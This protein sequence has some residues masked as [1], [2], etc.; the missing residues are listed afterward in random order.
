MSPYPEPKHIRPPST[1]TVQP[2]SPHEDFHPESKCASMS[3]SSSPARK[4]SSQRR[5]WQDL[6][7]TPLTSSG[8]HYLQSLPLEDAVFLE[9][10]GAMS[11]ELRHQATL[12][13]QRC[14]PPERHT[15]LT[16]S[17]LPPTSRIGREVK[18]RS[19]TLPRDSGLHAI[20]AAT[21]GASE[22]RD[23]QQHQLGQMYARDA[24]NNQ[25]CQGSK[26]HSEHI[27]GQ[28]WH[29]LKNWLLGRCC[30]LSIFN[31]FWLHPYF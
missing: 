13:P 29:D 23:V 8:L 5:S 20:L 19:F 21:A 17:Q 6:I 9:P 28:I 4:S 7:E 2:R 16:P 11:V 27:I 24:G 12:P 18:H 1:E 26:N 10:N 22:H 15:P 30:S 31:N 3:G 25:N 14:Q